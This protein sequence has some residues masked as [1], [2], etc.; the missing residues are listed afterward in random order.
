MVTLAA[1][2]AP[3]QS[4]QYAALADTL[5]PYELTLSPLGAQIAKLEMLTLGGQNYLRFDLPAEPDERQLVE[6]GML[7]TVGPLF[8]CYEQIGEVKGPLLRPL[9]TGFEPALPPVLM[10]ARRYRGKTN[11]MFTH[12]MCN[13]ARFSSGVR[14]HPWSALR[15]FDPLSG[16]GTTLFVALVLGASVA[17]VEREARTA[18]STAAFLKQFMREQGIACRERRER[19]KGV[20]RRWVFTIGEGAQTCTIAC[21]DTVNSATLISGFRPHLIVTDLPYGVQHKGELISLL[22]NS[23]PVWAALLPPGGS[24]V[25]AWDAKRFP[26][27]EMI[28]LVESAS[29]LSVLNDPPYDSLAHRVDRVIKQRDVLVARPAESLR[30]ERGGR[31]R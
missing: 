27:A 29:P 24:L 18:Q 21:G 9:D 22:S 1:Q 26:R 30:M 12:F 14:D 11:E 25:M 3:Q 31:R 20:G 7:A 4:T 10:R 6:L 2:I 19:F 17:G 28:A 5:A 8:V 23:L 13:L 15:V 16:G